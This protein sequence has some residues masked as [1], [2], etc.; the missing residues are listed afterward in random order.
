[1]T[2]CILSS[3]LLPHVVVVAAVAVVLATAA[4]AVAFGVLLPIGPGANWMPS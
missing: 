4:A 3:I 2:H 1:M